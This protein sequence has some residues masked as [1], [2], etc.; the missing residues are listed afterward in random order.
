VIQRGNDWQPCFF[1]DADYLRYLQELREPALK[2]HCLMHA[3]VLMTNHV[4][5]LVTPP[6]SGQIGRLMQALG[7]RYARYVNNRY[8]RTGTLWEGRY[9]ACLVDR[10][11]YLLHCYRYIEL[12]PARARMT[13]APED[14]RWSSHAANA[15]GTPDLLIHPHPNYIA[16]GSTD[17]A[18]QETYRAMVRQALSDD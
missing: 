6:T 8:R 18:R 14:Y 10:D 2:A 12:N 5:L 16:L 4:H 15:F 1:A 7:R 17:V 3:Y 13:A 11:T 9:K